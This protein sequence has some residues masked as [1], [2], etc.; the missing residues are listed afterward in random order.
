MLLLKA[1]DPPT[2]VKTGNSA[3]EK[4][5]LMNAMVA[6][7]SSSLGNETDPASRTV[8]FMAHSRSGK[9]TSTPLLLNSIERAPVTFPRATLTVLRYL[10]LLM[11]KILAV[12]KLIPSSE[13]RIVSVI[14]TSEHWVTSA[15]N[16]RALRA[17]R[18]TQLMVPT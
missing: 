15:V 5:L 2:E 4:V 17:G 6:L 16:S 18:V 10:L 9:E 3:E 7:T 8:M 14:K 1:K 13:V 12:T 11:L